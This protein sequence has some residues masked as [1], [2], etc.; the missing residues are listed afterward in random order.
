MAP[1]RVFVACALALAALAPSARA[2]SAPQAP[3]PPDARPMPPQPP[4]IVQTI[5]LKN[6][7]ATNDMNDITTAVRNMEPQIRIYADQAQKSLSISAKPEDMQPTLQL[8]TEL[9][10]PRKVFRLTYT[11][12]EMDGGRR[13]SQRQF[14]FLAA[15]GER[16]V[17]KQGGRVPIVTGSS[18][19]DRSGPN[20]QVQY[21]DIGMTIDATVTGSEDNLSLD[22]RVEQTSLADDK[23]TISIPDPEL[24]QTVLQELS[25]LTQGKPLVLGSLDLPG[26]SLQQQIAVTAELVR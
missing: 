22:T 20:Y 23:A 21:Q 12:A 15:T 9:D 26:T 14:V 25:V 3:P 19:E 10:Q 17:F 2:Q 4:R 18:P 6:A 5:F 11:I 1:I 7:T 24:H 16:S 13:V 8:I